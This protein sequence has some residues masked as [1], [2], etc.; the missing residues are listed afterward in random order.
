[1]S[2][3]PASPP[4][5]MAALLQALSLELVS[6]AA[7]K[8]EALSGGRNNRLWR[9]Q[10]QTGPVILK[11]YCPDARP[12]L[13]TEWDFLLHAQSLGIQSVP[14]PL[15][16][17]LNARLA[18]YSWVAGSAVSPS[19]L[20]PQDIQQYLAFLKALNPPK[21]NPLEFAP[22][23]DSCF[24]L[25]EHLHSLAKRVESLCAEHLDAPE[26]TQL[27]HQTLLPLWQKLE[28]QLAAWPE[29]EKP[30]AQSELW[31]SPSDVGFHNALRGPTGEWTFLD[32]EYAGR[33]HRLKTLADLLT[34]VGIPLP[35]SALTEVERHLHEQGTS[36]E[37]RRLFRHLLPLHQLKWCCI[38][39]GLFNP[40]A[41]RRRDFAGGHS[42]ALHNAQLARIQ[43]ALERAGHW[44]DLAQAPLEE[45]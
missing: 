21:Q 39:M 37:Q 45:V 40:A 1:M 38:L 15:G 4:V 44:Y 28:K 6:P 8:T 22:A 32:F 26:A 18:L 36:V 35:L 2:E 34:S 29:L 12:R 27:L 19:E 23:S 42:A 13:E 16:R 14:Q 25:A 41:A 31:L 7:F 3:M 43:A 10:T 9:L 33:D 5:E 30:F 17:D 24:S 11:A 20:G